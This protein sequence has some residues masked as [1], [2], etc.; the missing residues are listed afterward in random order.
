VANLGDLNPNERNPRRISEA[1]L[2]ALRKSL[3]EFGPLDGF[4]FNSRS[5]RLVGGHQR[6]KSLPKN[7]PI[8]IIETISKPNSQGTIARGFVEMENGERITYREVSWNE[9]KE[10]AA[11]I[12]ANKHS[13]E[14]ENETLAQLLSELNESEHELTGFETDEI[15]ESLNEFQNENAADIPAKV[16]DEPAL[17]LLRRVGLGC[18]ALNEQRGDYDLFERLKEAKKSDHEKCAEI[19]LPDF[20]SFD[21][22]NLLGFSTITYPPTEKANHPIKIVAENL[23]QSRGIKCEELFVPTS[24]TGRGTHAEKKEC[25]LQLNPSGACLVIDDVTTTGATLRDCVHSIKNAG[26]FAIGVAFIRTT[27]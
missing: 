7:S 15:Q 12:A 26:Q 16:R 25:L 3:A 23:S 18:F 5:K 21:R 6:K 2:S 27:D 10:K 11:M 13:G 22:D 4:V 24:R 19:M 8:T 9:Q 20:L 1:Q 14:W 17:F